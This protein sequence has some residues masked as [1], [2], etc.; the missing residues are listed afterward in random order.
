MEGRINSLFLHLSPVSTM[1]QIYSKDE[2]DAL[3]ETLDQKIDEAMQATNLVAGELLKLQEVTGLIET[4]L[5]N[6]EQHLLELAATR[7]TN[8]W[9]LYKET[10]QNA[11]RS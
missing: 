11:N 3:F 8:P 7:A 2:V 1:V 6:I 9:L 5:S 4:R 10:K